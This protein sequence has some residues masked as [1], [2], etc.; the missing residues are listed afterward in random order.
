MENLQNKF[1]CTGNVP[2]T[3]DT[4]VPYKN[5]LKIR[6]QIIVPSIVMLVLICVIAICVVGAPF[7]CTSD[8]P[9]LSKIPTVIP[10][11]E[12]ILASETTVEHVCS[13]YYVSKYDTTNHWNECS[14]CG[15][16]YNVVAHTYTETWT[17]GES[18]S[19]ANKCNHIC[20]CGY[21]Y[22][23]NNNREHKNIG[24]LNVNINEFVHYKLCLDCKN[25]IV[26]KRCTKEDGSQISCTNLGTCTVCGRDYSKDG[27][28]FW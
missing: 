7:G 12:E 1:Y 10:E 4:N 2:K 24:D 23:T 8:E 21:S 26:S 16:K 5:K 25:Y 14:I 9:S 28:T 15:K 11:D 22:Q 17:M 20:S 18:C 3:R 27:R 13:N 6:T 19:S